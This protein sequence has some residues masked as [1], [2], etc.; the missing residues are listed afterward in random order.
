MSKH[1]TDC[2]ACA[3]YNDLSRRDFLARSTAAA[4][5]AATPAWLPQVTYAQTEDT[6][7]DVIVSLFLRGGADGLSMV[8]PYGESAYYTAR[9]TIAVPRPDDASPNRAL[10]LNGFFGLPPAMASLLPAYRAGQLLIIHATGSTDP[11]RSHFDAQAF[12]EIGVPGQRE[13]ETGW[14]GRHLATK[15]PM[16]PNA[17]LRA[18]AFNY[19]LP[20][21][22]AGG[23]DT[24]P[25]PDPGNFGL[26]GTSSTRTQ[27][28][29]WL[30]TAFA[31]QPD[32]FKTSAINTQRTITQLS[33]IGISSY[34]PAGGAVYPTSSFG[35][36]L[37]STA[38]LI[39]ADVGVEAVHIDIGG[40]DTHSAQSPLTGSMAG[41]MRTLADAIAAF[42]ADMVGASRL[43]RL[44]LVAMSEFGRN[45]RENGS[46][47]TDHGHGNVM[48]VLGGSA[49]G[50]QVMTAWPGLSAGQ[51]YQQQDLQVTIDYRDILAEI[52]S[53]R[54]GNT[55]LDVVF[56]GFVP[57]FRGAVV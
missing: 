56:P 7:R 33:A 40:W 48:F 34:Q 31:S 8:V 41:T 15:P 17:A 55:Q 50:G 28:L 9:P 19:G 32:P 39:R 45:V 23:P 35:N 16:K 38:A 37:R 3:E 18:L 11:T 44:T 51:L 54:L 5:V 52:V 21:M 29:N 27:R 20:L 36:A 24:L 1:P 4:I 47:G 12:M 30:A 2:N 22:L 46:Q 53:R 42:H 43:G 25:I 49:V 57:T 6:T 14:L 10:D 26:A 13:V